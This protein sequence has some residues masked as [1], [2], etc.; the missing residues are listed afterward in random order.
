MSECGRCG[1]PESAHEHYRAG[2]DCSACGCPRFRAGA[3]RWLRAAGWTALGL[4]GAAGTGLMV[5]LCLAQL[6][7]GR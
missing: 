4:F 6:V 5:A 7:A 1:C 2:S 3:P